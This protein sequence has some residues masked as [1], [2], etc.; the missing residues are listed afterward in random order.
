M[1]KVGNCMYVHVSAISEF[2]HRELQVIDI[3]AT[4]LP[5]DFEFEIIKFNSGDDTVSFIQ[6]EDW[7][8]ANEPA[9]GDCYNIKE[10][11]SVKFIKS[12]GQIYH[13]KWTFVSKDYTGFDIEESK[14]R[15]DIVNKI[16]E[17]VKSKIGYRKFWEQLLEENGINV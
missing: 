17:G 9:V 14:R 4:L 11:G 16:S 2:S 15:S 8:T 6:S 13:H 1:K 12:K 7:N 3:A 10:D 5:E